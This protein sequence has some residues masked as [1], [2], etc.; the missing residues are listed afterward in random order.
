[1]VRR[2]DYLAVNGYTTT[3]DPASGFRTRSETCFRDDAVKRLQNS[4]IF[5]DF[6]GFEKF[7]AV[8]SFSPSSITD[9]ICRRLLM[10][11]TGSPRIL[12][13]R[14]SVQCAERITR[15]EGSCCG[16]DQ[17]IHQNPVTFVTPRSFA[18]CISICT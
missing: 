12:A 13:Q 3:T 5:H 8:D 9:E 18:T 4:F 7:R 14:D 2:L 15:G 16:C 11:P 10:F 17:R 6:S 1:M